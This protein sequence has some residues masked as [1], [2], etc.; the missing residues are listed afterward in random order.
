[1]G[2]SSLFQDDIDSQLHMV[3]LLRVGKL[4]SSASFDRWLYR[5]KH[6]PVSNGSIQ[7]FRILFV[8]V[9]TRMFL[10][11]AS[12]NERM[13]FTCNFAHPQTS[14]GV[15]VHD[16]PLCAARNPRLLLS[17]IPHEMECIQRCGFCSNRPQAFRP[18]CCPGR[19]ACSDNQ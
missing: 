7:L 4:L 17:C 1:M 15:T 19:T 18:I 14:V 6:K 9:C 13:K 16:N 11:C 5:N 2:N 3:I 8:C 12:V 10:L